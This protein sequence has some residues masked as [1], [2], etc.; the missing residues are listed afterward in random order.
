MISWNWIGFFRTWLTG[1]NMIR[2]VKAKLY[3]RRFI[4]LFSNN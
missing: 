4:D 2:H 1:D 3:E